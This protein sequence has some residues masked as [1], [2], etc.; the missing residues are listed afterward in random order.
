MDILNCFKI[1]PDLDM[2]PESGWISD[3]SNYIDVS[4]LRALWNCFDE[5]ALA[6]ALRL[7]DKRADSAESIRLHAITI[8]ASFC[9]QYLKTLFA[10][11]FDLAVRVECDKDLRFRPEMI[12]K[13][14]AAYAKRS[15]SCDVIMMGQQSTDGNNEKTPLLV[16]EYLGFRCVTQVADVISFETDRLVVECNTDEG[17]LIQTINTPCV[18]SVGNA[19]L[20]YLRVPTLKDKLT[21]G[22]RPILKL[23]PAELGVDLADDEPEPEVSLLRMLH[24]CKSR[25][26][27]K[28]EGATPSE[29]AEKLYRL[30]LKKRLENI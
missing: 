11:G 19:S 8:G 15:E 9:E 27:E 3:D 23:T 26:A 16:A 30:Y 10:L 29:K 5:S 24:I 4:Y 13:I 18:L 20:S 12:S 22:K 2:L 6:I 7:S 1:V 25:T 21:L 14:I 17:V 28:I